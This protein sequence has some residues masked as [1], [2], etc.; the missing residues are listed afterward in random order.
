MLNPVRG[1]RGMAVAP[2]ALAAQSALGVLRDGGNAVEAMVSAAATIAVVY[3]H[4]NSLGGDGF[5]L[6]AEPGGE[7][8]AVDACGPAPAGLTSAHYRE[9]GLDAV[10]ARG[11]LAANTVAGTVGGWQAALELAR[12]RWSARLPLSRL[13]SDARYYAANGIPVTASQEA[14]TE[15][16]LAELRDAPGFAQHYLIDGE[17]PRCGIRLVQPALAATLERLAETGLDDFYRG[18]L[19]R[20]IAADLAAAGSPVELRDLEAFRARVTR[21][22]QL[23]H[24]AGVLYNMPPPTQ[25]VVSLLILGILDRLGAR[26]MDPAGADFVHAAVEATKQAFAVR[27]RYVTDPAYMKVST[28]E[29]L[30]DAAVDGLA[31]A[32]D[33]ARA[34]PWPPSAPP[35]DT[36]WMGAVDASGLAVSF[37]QSIYYEYGSGVV[38]P[39]TGLCWQN[40]G[41]SFSLDP[42]ALQALAPGRKPFHTLNPAIARLADGRVAAYGTMGGDGQPQT[43]AAVFTRLAVF[44]FDPAHAVAAPRWLLGRT[45]GNP[46]DTLKLESRFPSAVID[47]LRRRGHELE[48]VGEYDEMM[49]HAGVVLRGADG[50]LSGAADPRS[51][52]AAAAF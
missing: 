27:D 41:A 39:A 31:G 9:R 8:I 22:L 21:P 51:D 42:D 4:M 3:P 45:W 5:W 20:A 28:D 18:E 11:P 47:D 30:A 52:G 48:L 40:R 13:L 6:V 10:P 15:Q 36:V 34:L 25:G 2:H 7:V 33:M 37:I 44:G 16:K 17:A 50:L 43:Q 46:S 12:R 38:L 23:A 1:T 19:A 49:G 24:S 35:A 29:L 26:G 32:V 14:S